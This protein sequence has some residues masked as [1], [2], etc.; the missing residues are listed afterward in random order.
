MIK[1]S[2][3]LILLSFFSQNIYSKEQTTDLIKY[4][5][6]EFRFTDS[7]LAQN[8]KLA[9]DSVINMARGTNKNSFFISFSEK[10]NSFL[11]FIQDWGIESILENKKSEEVFGF[12]SIE[13]NQTNYTF[14]ILCNNKSATNL[15]NQIFCKKCDSTVEVE[16]EKKSLNCYLATDSNVILFFSRI[17]DNHFIPM[18]IIDKGKII[19]DNRIIPNDNIKGKF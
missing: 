3:T 9:I 5:L 17:S 15:I 7:E 14:I 12:I 6:K 8:C 4:N 1:L 10:Y 2:L 13:H 11:C 18:Y 19:Y 16:P